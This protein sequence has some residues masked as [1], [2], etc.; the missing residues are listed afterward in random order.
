MFLRQIYSEFPS[1]IVSSVCGFGLEG[2]KNRVH[3]NFLVRGVEGGGEEEERGSV[4]EPGRREGGGGGGGK[5]GGE[6]EEEEEEGRQ[7]LEKSYRL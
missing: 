4:R 6:E 5:E 7:R 3:R 1:S 2:K